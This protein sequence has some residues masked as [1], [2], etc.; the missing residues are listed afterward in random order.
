[1]GFQRETEVTDMQSV[2]M[3]SECSGPVNPV[4]VSCSVHIH[5]DPVSTCFPSVKKEEVEEPEDPNQ[6]VYETAHSR[7]V[8]T[9]KKDFVPFTTRI[10]NFIS[11]FSEDGGAGDGSK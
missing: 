2:C 5:T 6:A 1:M 10:N 3:K 4:C 11:S 9:Y 7:T 8:I